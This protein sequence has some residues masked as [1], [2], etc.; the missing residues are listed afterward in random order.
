MTTPVIELETLD[1][2]LK[3]AIE[4]AENGPLVIT[5][6]GRPAYILRRLTD[7]D[8]I[9]DLLARNPSFLASIRRAREQKAAG[10]VKTLR[11]IQAKYIADGSDDA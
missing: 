2:E 3:A 6:N 11:E 7:D 5:S 8:L 9:D 1:A 4:A 10:K